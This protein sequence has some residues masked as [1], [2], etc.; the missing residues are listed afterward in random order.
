MIQL[1][2]FG[3]GTATLGRLYTPVSRADALATLTAA[4]AAGFTYIDTSPAYAEGLAEARVGQYLAQGGPADQA[5]VSTKVGRLV[6]ELPPLD[7]TSP[8]AV[9]MAAGQLHVD[10]SATGIEQSVRDSLTRLHRDQL[11]IAYLHDPPEAD[12]DYICEVS[13][14]ALRRLKE[15]G[16][17][18]AIGIGLNWADQATRLVRRLEL[19]V[20]LLAGRFTL[21]DQQ[22]L[23]EFLPSCL[24]RGTTMVAAGVFNTGVLANPE[25]G[26]T[27]NYREVPADVLARAQ[28][29]R[30]LCAIHDVD[31][32]A[33]A[34]HFPLLHPAVGSVVLGMRS[35]SEV[36]QNR[37]ARDSEIP[38]ALW[39]DLADHG[40]IPSDLVPTE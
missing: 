33:A 13:Y 1:P 32:A 21:L 8:D 7:L 24:E 27:Y 26:Q 14:P 35:P 22:A 12:E 30:T 2:R 9:T 17:V 31:L 38:V 34:M 40:H 4:V 5:V 36:A 3:I 23:A 15:E 6:D 39:Q 28:Q 37:L 20:V 29:L 18:G 16:L 10:W 11:D 19:D 25:P